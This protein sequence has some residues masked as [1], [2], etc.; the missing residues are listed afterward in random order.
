MTATTQRAALPQAWPQSQPATAPLSLSLSVSAALKA[1]P[2]SQPKPTAVLSHHY[3]LVARLHQAR[4]TQTEQTAQTEQTKESI[5]CIIIDMTD[6]AGVKE[7]A[8]KS[9]CAGH[10]DWTT[11][12]PFGVL[13]NS[14]S[15]TH[16]AAQT[17]CNTL[18][19]D[20]AD[21]EAIGLRLSSC[22]HLRR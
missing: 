3:Q 2:E 7:F 20:A 17:L 1:A 8:T 9:C 5:A 10:F 19:F 16:Y 12:S 15:G 11:L 22:K 4:P 18:Q 21:F 14:S 13:I 6:M